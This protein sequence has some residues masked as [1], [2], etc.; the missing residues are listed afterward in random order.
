[1]FL[2]MLFIYIMMLYTMLNASFTTYFKDSANLNGSYK[3]T[4]HIMATV[5]I[6]HPNIKKLL[7]DKT[8]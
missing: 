5:K 2:Q 8:R 6:Y 3:K 1:M 7:N 4:A